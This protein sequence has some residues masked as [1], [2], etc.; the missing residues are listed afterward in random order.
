MPVQSL[1]PLGYN[2]KKF[3]FIEQKSVCLNALKTESDKTTVVFLKVM[4]GSQDS[5]REFLEVIVTLVI[6]SL[7][8]I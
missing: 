4:N 1:N 7:F 2:Q 5:K 6:L 3:Y 8:H